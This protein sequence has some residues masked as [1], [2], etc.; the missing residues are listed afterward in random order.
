MCAVL[1]NLFVAV[2]SDRLRLKQ[3]KQTKMTE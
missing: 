1:F 2:L 3:Y